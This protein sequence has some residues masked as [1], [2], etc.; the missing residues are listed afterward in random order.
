MQV[1]ASSGNQPV[2]MTTSNLRG[3]SPVLPQ[4]AVLMPTSLPNQMK[5]NNPASQSPSKVTIIGNKGSSS[6][7]QLSLLAQHP[8]GHS[9]TTQIH[10]K[11]NT[12]GPTFTTNTNP[13]ATIQRQVLPVQTL[14]GICFVYVLSVIK[15][16]WFL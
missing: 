11:P 2:V 3:V 5:A 1:Q 13:G 14:P 9:A 15:F 16:H 7:S 4:G 12:S 8:Q 10:I 6:L